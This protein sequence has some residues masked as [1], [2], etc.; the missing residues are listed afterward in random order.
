MKK[1]LKRLKRKA[2]TLSRV[3]VHPSKREFRGSLLSAFRPDRCKHLL[4]SARKQNKM[5][6]RKKKP[7]AI[8]RMI[9]SM[10]RAEL[11]MALNE[12]ERKRI[13][14]RWSHDTS[15]ELGGCFGC[16]PCDRSAW[17]M[18]L[19]LSITLENAGQPQPESNFVS[20][21]KSS[22]SQT[23]QQNLPLSL[24]LRNS[25]ENALVG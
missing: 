13:I 21:E 20:E 4:A 14:G 8:N 17:A 23:T 2:N 7:Y 1:V 5:K 25:P 15:C 18:I 10:L 3:I 19:L 12:R 22:S 16:L 11:V 9:N 6:E 24:V